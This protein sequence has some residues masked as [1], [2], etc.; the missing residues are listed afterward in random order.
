MFLSLKLKEIYLTELKN[1]ENE[2]NSL[3]ALFLDLLTHAIFVDENFDNAYFNLSPQRKIRQRTL[4]FK[5]DVEIPKAE[6]LGNA[7]Y[8]IVAY[9]LMVFLN[10]IQKQRKLPDF[11]IHDG[12]FHGISPT[13]LINSVNYM[14]HA[15]LKHSEKFPFQYILTFNENEIFV[16]E[17]YGSFDFDVNE[18]IKAEY[19]D[20]PEKNDI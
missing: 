17:Q 19:Q 13:T 10:N 12:V 14:F 9:D 3:R 4:P 16:N 2:I 8:K 5:I 20:T 11:L 7:R 15:F 18:Y 6:A 1:F